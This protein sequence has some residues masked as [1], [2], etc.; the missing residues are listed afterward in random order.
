MRGHP[1]FEATFSF[2][3]EWPCDRESTVVQADYN[4]SD[5]H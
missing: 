3:K 2:W 1:S 5:M 4:I